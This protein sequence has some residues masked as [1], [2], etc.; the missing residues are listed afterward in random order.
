VPKALENRPRL[1]ES[2]IAVVDALRLLFRGQPISL[3]DIRDYCE[4][5]GVDDVERFVV[6]LKTTEDFVMRMQNKPGKK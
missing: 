1:D 3:A 2:T 6:L 4:I 5:F